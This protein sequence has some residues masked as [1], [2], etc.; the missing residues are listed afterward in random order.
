MAYRI[1]R[2][3]G[4]LITEV[5][6]G[7][8]DN[9]SIDLSL[10]GRNYAGF[11]EILNENFVKL[12]ENFASSTSPSNPLAGQLWY[13]KNENRL[14]IYDGTTFRAGA[15]PIVADT[16]PSALVA[17]DI[18]MDS[19][20]DQM[21]FFDGS[22]EPTLA[23]PVYG[24]SQGLSGFVVETIKDSQLQPVT[25]TKLYTDGIL[26]GA[27][28]PK[29]FD[30]LAGQIPELGNTLFAG[31]NAST[32]QAFTNNNVT[33]DV[34]KFLQD[35]QGI[36]RDAAQFLPTYTSG[37]INGKLTVANN[38]GIVIGSQGQ[39]THSMSSDRYNIINTRSNQT[40]AIAVSV[41]G[42]RENA[43]TIDTPNRALGIFSPT[44]EYTL[45]VGGDARITGNLRVDGALTT[46]ST[47]EVVV[48]DTNITLGSGAI[49]PADV[50]GGGITLAGADVTLNYNVA[51]NGYWTSSIDFD[52]G[53]GKGYYI[54]NTSVLS[55]TTLGASI[56]N[57]SLTSVG[58]LNGL[59]LAG[60]TGITI[61][62]NLI[63]TTGTLNLRTGAGAII[64]GEIGVAKA[65]IKN[66]A[67]P[68]VAEDATTKGYVDS[69][70][71]ANA[72]V[73]TVQGLGGTVRIDS[74]RLP[75]GDQ[76][77]AEFYNGVEWVDAVYTNGLDGLSIDL[78]RKYYTDERV[79]AFLT[80]NSYTTTTYVNT[81]RDN[82]IGT[83]VPP[84]NMNTLAEISASINNIVDFKG[85]VDT[86]VAT[87]ISAGTNV[88]A[89]AGLVDAGNTLLTG[90]VTI[91]ISA[92]NG[93]I[94]TANE[95]R[96]DMTVF[97]TDDLTEGT[98]NLYFTALRSR[99][100]LQGST[101]VT[102]N[103]ITGAIAI[104]Q[105]IA[106]A[107]APVF[108]G[109]QTTG[110]TILGGTTTQINSPNL[111]FAG[112]DLIMNSDV[113]G[114]PT[115]DVDFTIQRGTG[116]NTSIRWNETNDQ[117]EF[118]NNGI[119]YTP[120]GSASVF[121]GTTDGVP[122]G[123]TN[124]YFTDARARAA[125]SGG[126]GVTLTGATGVI[127]IGQDVAQSATPTFAGIVTT[128]LTDADTLSVLGQ[129]EL[130]DIIITGNTIS[131]SAASGNIN[132]NATGVG[133]V[134]F[135]NPVSAQNITSG[136]FNTDG[137]RLSGNRIQTVV[138]SS[139]LEL[140][141]NGG[142]IVRVLTALDILGDLTVQ[143]TTTTVN[144]S[145]LNI[146]DNIITLNSGVTGLPT[147]NAGIEVNRGNLATTAIRWNETSDT[148]EFSNDGIAYSA[149][150][151]NTTALTEGTNLYYTQARFD[152]ALAASTT[153]ELS[154]GTTNQYYTTTR[155][156][157]DFNNQNTTNLTEGTNLYFTDA[158]ARLAIS[159][160]G[161]GSYDDATG[162]ITIDSP[163]DS[164]NG[165]TGVVVLT[166]D[167]IS[168][169][170]NNEY[171]T[172]AKAR[173]SLAGATGVTYNNATGAIAIGQEVETTSNVQFNNGVFDGTMGIGGQ[174]IITGDVNTV[175]Y[176][177]DAQFKI[178]GDSNNNFVLG[179][180]YETNADFA[181]IEVKETSQGGRTL[182]IQPNG[183]DTVGKI[184]I[185][186]TTAQALLDVNGTVKALAVDTAALNVNEMSIGGTLNFKD[187]II[188]TADSNADLE[189]RPQGTGNVYI[190]N[191]KFGIGYDP[192]IFGG[193][194]QP[195]EVTLD[196]NS[197]DQVTA[198]RFKNTESSADAGPYINVYRDSSN[199]ADADFIGGIQL[200]GND[201]LG[202]ETAYN[203]I[204]SKI[205]DFTN[206]T[207]ASQTIFEN[208]KN[209]VYVQHLFGN[210]EVVFNET[211]ADVNFRVEGNGAADA[212]FIQG[213]DGNVGLGTQSP[214]QRLDINGNIGI[215]SI[216][217]VTAA[218]SLTNIV[219]YTGTGQ[220][221]INGAATLG[222]AT[223]Q[224][225]HA[226][227]GSATF[228][229]STNSLVIDGSEIKSQGGITV[230]LDTDVSGGANE[231]F[232]VVNQGNTELFSVNSSTGVA[233]FASAFSLPA[234]DGAS[235]QALLTNGLG[236]VSWQTI[237]STVVAEGTNLYY[238]QSRFD[239]AFGNKSTTN[240]GEGL[241]LYYT[242][243]RVQSKLSSISG[244]MLP[245]SNGTYDVGSQI[246]N[247]RTGYFSDGI[248]IGV[249]SALSAE[250]HVQGTGDQEIRA[251]STSSGEAVFQG[252]G[253]GTGSGGRFK[254][255][256]D[257]YIGGSNSSAIYFES[258]LA[259]VM[260]MNAS[261]FIVGG[262]TFSNS[263]NRVMISTSGDMQF[264]TNTTAARTVQSFRNINGEIGSISTDGTTTA[265]NTTS[266]YRLKEEIGSI[267]DAVER[268]NALRPVKFTYLA[269]EGELVHDGFIAH[270]VDEIAPRAVY[271]EKDAVED[272]GRIK[273]QQLD[274][275]KL[276]PL[277]TSALQDA[278]SK[279]EKL[280]E[281]LS[282]LENK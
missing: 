239:T 253:S 223:Y 160:S 174:T 242:D 179:M 237:S 106:P 107:A 181:F 154:E 59:T 156:N 57:S 268:V 92:G 124:L 122:E 231:Y 175:N 83:P 3:D 228:S 207:K 47:T 24:K 131:H 245:T 151:G 15:G 139:D 170:S 210:D 236:A 281:R 44:P 98:V 71:A 21:Y 26:L 20:E 155:F 266:D 205:I 91:N 199:P 5:I 40:M 275:S 41:N 85:Y 10:I 188:S 65:Q 76:G 87:R 230:R 176:A 168:E 225:N 164:V 215:G 195:A 34:A 42:I 187:N 202:V 88:F 119:T 137:V 66:L 262:G 148:W 9:N 97:D 72:G 178:R 172:L 58:V 123:I 16:V 265:F 29:N 32:Q 147:L 36:N 33:V 102:Y 31:F 80:N 128:G 103:N 133:S 68:T 183:T 272:D 161:D 35:A 263:A 152:A 246:N 62:D 200:T 105:D 117:W 219:D 60:G 277:L 204:R 53:L 43:I 63:N 109:L 171:F 1:N 252:I 261:Q 278:L 279:I 4:T 190:P 125:L 96:V 186:K 112:N 2:T 234:V 214:V 240:L 6:D 54:N 267:D 19:D 90:D 211:G 248:G 130:G 269:D 27:Y 256:P 243:A 135:G 257:T 95:V 169:G 153:D 270:E 227:N 49:T 89:G 81:I 50:N 18:W 177:V 140:D 143:G 167:A 39:V 258:G 115:E 22:G 162:I 264:G 238:T 185:G 45:D 86:E 192:T 38:Q 48:A 111:R 189:F 69:L 73:N 55:S 129:S 144:S 254:G 114:A 197:V 37:T 52:L 79:Q 77:N 134:I 209:N 221:S 226:I 141:A 61:N 220:L 132:I 67:D 142:G 201:N 198:A 56:V 7:T 255:N 120:L 25:I 70:V 173:L 280:E 224:S 206:P 101:G 249:T 51:D 84:S 208:L 46:I 30:P 146:A 229:S 180:G 282:K 247:F 232:K 259:E 127:A 165:L 182:A 251:Q 121:T 100:A 274:H 126:T 118:S 212:L 136:E 93:I 104:G 145:E 110:N 241:N 218:R 166:T 216:T 194:D 250:I 116:N 149:L 276:V 113:T 233:R 184:A 99:Q 196:V 11:G 273:P 157:A 28:A 244:S 94:A 75:E 222:D 217:V 82:I 12:L 213:S 203:K 163:V 138:S 159:V 78:N 64:I 235:N 17:G 74:N 260:R 191:G 14:K 271:G 23:G 193:T 108:A 158:R 8:I 13:D 150:P